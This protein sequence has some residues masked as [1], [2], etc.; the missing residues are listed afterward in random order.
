[1]HIA[2]LKAVYISPEKPF[3]IKGMD[4]LSNPWKTWNIA[5]ISEDNA[6]VLADMGIPWEDGEPNWRKHRKKIKQMKDNIELR[7]TMRR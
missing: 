3:S 2:F 4:V 6:R 1:M 5:F 7:K